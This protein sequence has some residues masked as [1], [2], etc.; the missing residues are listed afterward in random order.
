MSHKDTTYFES[1]A[2]FKAFNASTKILRGHPTFNRM[3]PSPPGPNMAPSFND[4]QDYSWKRRTSSCCGN[5]NYIQSSQTKKE[6][7]G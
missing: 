7:C 5:H 2:F 4:N 6:A 3:C 1:I